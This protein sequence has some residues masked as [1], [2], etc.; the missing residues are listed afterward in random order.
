MK[1]VSFTEAAEFRAWLKS[2]HDTATELLLVFY[3]KDSGRAG[4]TYAEALDEALCFG[5]ID[6]LRK[7]VDDQRYTI[8]FTPRKSG[9]I[10]SNI[11][12]RHVERLTAARRMQPSGLK[13]FAA[14]DAKK[15]GVY[16]FEK[17]PQT[18]PPE[19]EQQ[20]RA[21]RK[22][23]AFFTAQA[24]WYQRTAIHVVLQP[25]QEATRQRWLDRL[26]ADSAQ[27]RRLARLTPSQA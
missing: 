20:F 23:W 11:N 10:W 8:R 12:V 24:P 7:R 2:H 26:I 5:W 25:K 16:S 19:F 4:I 9:S 14:R 18:F 22:A 15:T 3:K 17:P 1:P 27:G 6:G 13:I 21:N